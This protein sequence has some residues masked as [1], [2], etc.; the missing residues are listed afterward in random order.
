[1]I[2]GGLSLAK[3]GSPDRRGMSCR[4]FDDAVCERDR[5]S[6]RDRASRELG[7]TGRYGVGEVDAEKG[8]ERE[9]DEAESGE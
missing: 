1:M 6:A 2:A 3:G 9:A 4:S 8:E 7:H 5:E